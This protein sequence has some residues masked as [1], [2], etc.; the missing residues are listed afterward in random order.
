MQALYAG[1]KNALDLCMLLNEVRTAA[2][3]AA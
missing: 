3:K 2:V 1:T